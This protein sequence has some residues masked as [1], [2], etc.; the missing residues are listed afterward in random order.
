MA[1]SKIQI[2]LKVVIHKQE[3]R[4][5]YAEANSDFVH[6][7]ILF[8]FLT[9]PMGTIV[10]LLS[11]PASNSSQQPTIGSL[12]NL[13]KSVANLEAKYFAQGA[14]KDI[15]LN[16][17]NSAEDECRKLKINVNDI[18]PIE[19]YTCEDMDCTEKSYTAFFSMYD[20]VKCKNCSKMLNRCA[21]IHNIFENDVQGVFVNP[22]ES[23]LITNDLHV[24]PNVTASILETSE[25]TDIE[26]L[27]EKTLQIG[28]SEILDLLKYSIL[29]RTPL[30]SSRRESI[31]TD[32]SVQSLS[33]LM[34]TEEII[35]T[36]KLVQSLNS[37]MSTEE[38]ISFKKME[39]KVLVQ[40][41]KNKIILVHS[42]EDFI[43][44]L[45]SFLPLPLGRVIGLVGKG[46]APALSVEN[47]HQSVSNLRVD[48]YFNWK[49]M[50]DMLLS[51]KLSMLY[52]CPEQLFPLEEDRIPKF[53]QMKAGLP[54][55]L[56]QV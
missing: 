18:S 19:Y 34:S 52:Q 32:K 14:C 3:E 46:Y 7:D 48:G 43:E 44:F 36:D 53:C 38:I 24:I 2:P 12:N 41:S 26:V 35:I 40:K 29:S 15:L 30:T 4:V 16:T 25:S 31:I 11:R 28:W 56:G 22:A 23:F 1:A 54:R 37:H 21:N 5:L 47:L 27:E 20:G 42:S 50:K 9:M 10:R 33:S 8:S 49:E 51:P 39:V 17:R 55:I 6:I 45:F 13:Y